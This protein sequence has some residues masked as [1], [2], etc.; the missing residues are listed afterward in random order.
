MTWS[1]K[2]VALVLGSFA[3]LWAALQSIGVFPPQTLADMLAVLG[4]PA[5][6]RN[7]LGRMT[8]LMLAGL[9][10]FVALRAGLFNI[11]AEG[12]I[13]M[14]GLGAV[15][16]GLAVPGPVGIVGAM[17]AGAL[18]GA[19]WAWPAGAIKAWRGGHEVIT[20]I[21]LNQIAFL[22]ITWLTR[23]PLKGDGQTNATTAS[24]DEATRL[25]NLVT[26][27]PF[28]WN[29]A[30]F[31]AVLVVTATIVWLRRSVGGYE[32]AAVGS[33]PKAAEVAGVKTK[34][35]LWKAMAASGAL[36]GLAGALLVL[37]SDFRL[38]P[39]LAGGYGFDALGVA[40][41]CGPTAWALIP[42]AFLF[43]LVD[44]GTAN[45]SLDGIPKGVSSLLLGLVILVFAA[46]RFRRGG[47]HG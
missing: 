9:A 24:L 36:S 30:F 46:F 43:A 5:G 44:V 1:W 3:V 2:H 14:G 27:G 13:L 20:T 4:K 12:Q 26:Q 23:G 40:L 39:G 31:V 35:I 29:L 47:T 38:F 28:R 34:T 33:G 21:M 11:G 19:L 10:V 37:S 41:L 32:L 18:F 6:W 7:I 22:F 15:L 8:P 45:L 16:V 17:L 25:P 42:S